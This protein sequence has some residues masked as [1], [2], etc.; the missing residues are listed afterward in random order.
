[1]NKIE[2]HAQLRAVLGDRTPKV[3]EKVHASLNKQAVEF[4]QRSPFLLLATSDGQG[5]LE[6]SPKGDK[7]GFVQVREGALWLPDRTGN[8]MLLGFENILVNPNVALIF[9]VPHTTETLRVHGTAELFQDE[10]L[11]REMADYGHDALLV[12]K[13]TVTEAFFHCGKAL[14]RSHLW[15]PDRWGEGYKVN[16]GYEMEHTDDPAV[17]EKWDQAAAHA[18]QNDL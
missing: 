12:T 2:T 11:Q 17:R 14:V 1:M 8:R 9:L 13:V 15:E 6:V 3:D 10:A 5:N 16:W 18:Y 7:P 4:I